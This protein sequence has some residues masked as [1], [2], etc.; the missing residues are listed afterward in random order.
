MVK[1]YRPLCHEINSTVQ[2][3]HAEVHKSP[4]KHLFITL[5]LKL[6]QQH[7]DIPLYSI[8]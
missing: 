5:S 6:Q 4:H 8:L 1:I 2:Y 7:D 3:T